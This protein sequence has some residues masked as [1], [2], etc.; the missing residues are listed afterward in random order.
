MRRRVPLGLFG[1]ALAAAACGA[2]DSRH[3]ELAPR[4]RPAYAALA[5]EPAHATAEPA[6]EPSA[7]TAP[8]A[9]IVDEIAPLPRG[10]T[11][12]HIGDS[13]AD[14][15]GTALRNELA[16]AGVRLVTRH[17]TGSHIPEWGGRFST[18]PEL[19][20]A[21]HPDLVLVNLGGND[22][23]LD[24][25]TDR[26]EGIRRIVSYVS[27]RP[28]VWIA[29]PL[30]AGENGLLALLR[31]HSRPCR[32]FDTNRITPNLPRARP[33]PIHPSWPA[34]TI[35]AQAVVDWLGHERDPNGPRLWE[36]RPAPADEH[37]IDDDPYD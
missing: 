34:R 31:E 13:M 11:V 22:M 21:Y 23:M 17:R 25:P 16:R 15:L 35:W 29:P 12:L 30:W 18:V 27:G 10:T 24:D 32:W 36:L 9:S 33:D 37:A 2:G 8:S 7:S 4:I 20:R 5:Q 19:V 14:A 3:A 6:P 26:V 1:A 28:C